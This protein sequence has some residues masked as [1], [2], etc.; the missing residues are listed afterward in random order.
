MN[1]IERERRLD[2]VGFTGKYY[3]NGIPSMIFKHANTYGGNYRDQ[4]N[5]QYRPCNHLN[6]VRT[7]IARQIGFADKNHGEDSDY[8]DRLLASGLIRRESII[9][10][11]PTS[12]VL[13]HYFFSEENSRTHR[14]EYHVQ[15]DS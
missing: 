7:S 3:I 10:T 6:P 5:I 2:S 15:E 11:G 14:K 13:Y 1:C 4:N 9:Q 12:P 8:S